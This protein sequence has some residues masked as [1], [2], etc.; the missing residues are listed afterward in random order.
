MKHREQ[1]RWNKDNSSCKKTDY[2]AFDQSKYQALY[3][4]D[5]YP[6]EVESF[7]K[8][9]MKYKFKDKSSM[10]YEAMTTHSGNCGV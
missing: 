1:Q 5:T 8:K 2:A 4:L 7:I 3:D 6:K 10:V 9:R